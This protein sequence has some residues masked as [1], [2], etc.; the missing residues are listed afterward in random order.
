MLDESTQQY[1]AILKAAR[2]YNPELDP[3]EVVVLAGAVMDDPAVKF[4]AANRAQAAPRPYP[5]YPAIVADARPFAVQV[6]NEMQPG[7]RKA[8][9][10]RAV[11]RAGIAQA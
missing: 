4:E 8:L 3:M 7:D 2:I 9:A 5:Q 1:L 10:A 11:R 6:I